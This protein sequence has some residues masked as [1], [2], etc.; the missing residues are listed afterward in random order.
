MKG[1][2]KNK[3][4]P[5]KCEQ[6][7]LHRCRLSPS[8]CLLLALCCSSTRLCRLQMLAEVCPKTL[9][10]DKLLAKFS[11]SYLSVTDRVLSHAQDVAI[12]ASLRQHLDISQKVHTPLNPAQTAF[13]RQCRSRADKPP[14]CLIKV[15][16]L[17]IKQDGKAQ[18]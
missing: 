7:G 14:Q 10:A 8:S 9:Q 16:F 5:L 18:L 3:V 4:L 1:F 6:I 17:Q 11:D 12:L 13:N 2:R 15:A